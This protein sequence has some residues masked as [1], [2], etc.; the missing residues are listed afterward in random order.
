MIQ[1]LPALGSEIHQ[2]VEREIDRHHDEDDAGGLVGE[3][4]RQITAHLQDDDHEEYLQEQLRDQHDPQLLRKY[5]IPTAHRQL[6]EREAEDDQERQDDDDGKG[7]GA[8]KR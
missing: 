1:L 2:H 7:A 8:D 5:L 3:P 4:Q 6:S